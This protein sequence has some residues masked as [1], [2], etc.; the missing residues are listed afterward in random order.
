M[1]NLRSSARLQAKSNTSANNPTK[2]PTATGKTVRAPR[3]AKAVSTDAKSIEDTQP[4]KRQ[5]KVA[6]DDAE[7]QSSHKLKSGRRGKLNLMAEMPLDVLFEIFSHLRPADLLSLTKA[8]VFLR[9]MLYNPPAISI[10]KSVGV[11]VI[12]EASNLRDYLYQAILNVDAHPSTPS[13]PLEMGVIQYT[14]LLY[15]RHC[16]VCIFLW[17]ITLIL[18]SPSLV[19]SFWKCTICILG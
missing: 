3:K 14:K 10:W 11:G 19:L 17:D 2:N 4:N 18:T 7:T 12:L 16:S 1:P 13:V 9:D 15:G 8:N 6:P 5:K